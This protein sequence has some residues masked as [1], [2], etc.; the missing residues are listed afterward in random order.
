[1]TT[2]TEVASFVVPLNEGVLNLE[3]D[4]RLSRVSAGDFVYTTNVCG[5]L[6]PSGLPPIV[7]LA[8]ATTVNAAFP[9]STGSA[10]GPVFQCPEVSEDS[11]DTTVRPS[12]VSPSCTSTFT[13]P[14]PVLETV[15]LNTGEDTRDRGDTGSIVTVGASVLTS[16]VIAWLC[17]DGFPSELGSGACTG[18]FP[19]RSSLVTF[20]VFHFPAPGV[21]SRVA[22]TTPDVPSPL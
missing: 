2:V 9:D 13:G 16:K 22:F 19:L 4:G 8:R 1:M 17:P 11:V 15:P 14:L 5:A 6:T 20:A 12:G 18:Y 3:S 10:T 7:L 21:A